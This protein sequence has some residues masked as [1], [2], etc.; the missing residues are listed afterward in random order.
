MGGDR[1]TISHAD[2]HLASVALG[3]KVIALLEVTW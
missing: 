1:F 3:G 2:V